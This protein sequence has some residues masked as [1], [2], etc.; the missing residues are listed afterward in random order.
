[1]KGERE[2][3]MNVLGKDFL[4]EEV[5][6]LRAFL[7]KAQTLGYGNDE[8]RGEI[9]KQGEKG[10]NYVENMTVVGHT[11]PHELHQA[12]ESM[13]EYASGVIQTDFSDGR[14][15]I[16]YQEND[17]VYEDS[18]VGG[19]PFAGMTTIWF[20]GVACW[21]M[22]YMGRVK[23]G[24]SKEEIYPCLWAALAKVSPEYP[25]RGPK[26]MSYNDDEYWYKN[27]WSGGLVDF[28]GEETITSS[29][30]NMVGYEMIYHGG[31]VNLS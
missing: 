1:M 26:Y 31:V 11:Q 25:Y 15:T 4:K 28:T 18:W 24:F 10:S 22:V 14:H 2:T 29:N 20:R 23:S 27:Q 9:V 13:K 12:G 8:A 19:E 30:D 5:D 3:D 21:S 17:W 16:R 7:Y 6:N